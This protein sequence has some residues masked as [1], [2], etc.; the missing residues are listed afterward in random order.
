[1]KPIMLFKS[2]VKGYTR[3]DGIYV[4]EHENSVHPNHPINKKVVVNQKPPEPPE[5]FHPQRNDKGKKVPIKKLSQPTPAETWSDSGAMATVTAHNAK[6]LPDALFGVK[7]ESWDDAPTTLH[8]W[9]EVDGQVEIDEPDFVSKK[10][11]AQGSGVIVQ[12]DD[13]RVWVVHPTNKFGGY[14]ANFPKGTLEEG[15][16]LQASA[17]KE[18]YEESG[19]KVEITGFV[20]DIQR[21]TSVARYYTARRIG[22]TPADMGWESQSV[23]LVPVDM[24][25]TVVNGVADAP[26]VKLIK[27]LK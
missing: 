12:E 22:G 21:T 3:K 15:L 27:S 1:M 16:P 6:A 4:V 25:H 20:G 8:D 5:G 23:S 19:L 17:I 9:A 18:A 11:M 7:F 24:L 2:H 26:L 13:G 14:E 10:G